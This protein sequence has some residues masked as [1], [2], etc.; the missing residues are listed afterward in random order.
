M[1]VQWVATVAI[2]AAL[3]SGCAQRQFVAGHGLAPS[4][5]VHIVTS[6][7]GATASTNYGQ[8]CETPCYLPLLR[9]RGG[10]ITVALEG[11]HTER[12]RVTSSVDERRIANRSRSFATEAIDPDPI[13][14]LLS[15]VAQTADGEGG[16]MSLDERDFQITMRPLQPGEEDLLASAE[17]ISGERIPIDVSEEP[18]TR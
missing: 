18:A 8:H 9:D 4:E 6:P 5:T 15:A 12:F 1:K 11:H 10:E 14:I 3:V 17:P 16:V 2:G 13:G 7:S